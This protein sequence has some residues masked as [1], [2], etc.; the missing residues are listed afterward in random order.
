M[1]IAAT[2]GLVTRASSFSKNYGLGRRLG[3]AANG[4]NICWISTFRE[5]YAAASAHPFSSPLRRGGTAALLLNAP[6][7]GLNSVASCPARFEQG[8]HYLTL[9]S[10]NGRR[11]RFRRCSAWTGIRPAQGWSW[12]RTV[13]IEGEEF[14][15]VLTLTP[16]ERD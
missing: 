13:I 4:E 3:I 5:S 6:K 11:M 12:L 9:T 8:A 15:G 2:N 10:I 1:A 7:T 14:S 16:R